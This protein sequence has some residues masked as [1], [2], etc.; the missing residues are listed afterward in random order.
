MI[1]DS[2]RCDRDGPRSVGIMGF[3]L[4]RTG[5]G[6]LNDLVQFAKDTVKHQAIIGSR[7]PGASGLSEDICNQI[8][9]CVGEFI[10]LY[11][12]GLLAL[13]AVDSIEICISRV[14]VQSLAQIP[15]AVPSV[16]EF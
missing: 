7:T 13:M 4:D 10:P 16:V 8:P 1:G 11:H 5:R 6:S 15:T 3:H 2:K 12:L 9:G 14:F